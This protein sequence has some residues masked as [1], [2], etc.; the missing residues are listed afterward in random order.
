MTSTAGEYGW[1]RIAVLLRMV[2]VLVAMLTS[3]TLLSAISH[4]DSPDSVGSSPAGTLD[5][6]ESPAASSVETIHGS[7]LGIV[8][9]CAVVG[10][11]CL[12]LLVWRGLKRS[13]NS[14]IIRPRR[15]SLSARKTTGPP[16]VERTLDL[17]LLSISRT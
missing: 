2:L 15:A 16:R 12:L 1:G 7:T 6:S 5:Q 17:Q 10:L 3:L 9:G 14:V 4:F 8:A 13:N 11:C